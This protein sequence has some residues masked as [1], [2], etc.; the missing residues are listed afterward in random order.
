LLF[1]RPDPFKFLASLTLF[2]VLAALMTAAMVADALFP[3]LGVHSHWTLVT[4]I[5]L[6]AINLIACTLD[7]RRKIGWQVFLVHLGILVIL[8]GA[9]L[10]WQTAQRGKLLLEVGDT[11][12]N[13]AMDDEAMPAFKL[14][15]GVRLDNF[16]L[17]YEGEP[18]H[19]IHL[20][21]VDGSWE[22]VLFV[23]PGGQYK[24]EGTDL[25]LETGDFNPDLVVDKRGVSQRSIEPRNPALRI[26]LIRGGKKSEPFW[27][28][29]LFPGMHQEELPVKITYSYKPAP[30]KQYISDV[31]IFSTDGIEQK[32][33]SIWVNHPMHYAGWTL[34]QSGYDPENAKTSILEV[35]RDPGVPVVYTGFG[36]LMLGLAAVVLRRKI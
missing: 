19:F 25:V 20:W 23:K 11:P 1:V 15:F 27:L 3:S 34:Y 14:P 13:T 22:R 5:A 26:S 24:V 7:K 28:F 9:A 12:D 8:A 6:I 32:M 21:K 2:I 30:L 18:E 35:V 36:I 17:E 29:A 4:G 10:T 31:K 16:R 33:D